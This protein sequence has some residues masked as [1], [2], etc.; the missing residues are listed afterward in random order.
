MS[1]N[2]IELPPA[3]WRDIMRHALSDETVEVCGLLTGAFRLDGKG[4]ER[5][6]VAVIKEFIP[7]TN[8]FPD[9]AIFFKM[10]PYEQKVVFDRIGVDI[11]AVVGCFHTHPFG[12]GIPSELDRLSINEDYSWL[13]YGGQDN[14]I[15]AWWPEIKERPCDS[16]CSQPEECKEVIIEKR[17]RGALLKE[18]R[19]E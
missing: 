17:F 7:I 18:K 13:I 12:L 4:S 11:K 5:H 19:I 9:P 10:D 3:I 8:I 2:R 15:Q 1:Y 16:C 14:K 6:E